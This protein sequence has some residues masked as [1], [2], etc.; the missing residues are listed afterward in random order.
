MLLCVTTLNIYWIALS[1]RPHIPGCFW[2]RRFFLPY[3]RFSTLKL[4]FLAPKNAGFRKVSHV[5]FKKIKQ[6][7]A[8]SLF[9]CGLTKTEVSFNTMMWYVIQRMPC[10]GFYPTIVLAFSCGR[11]RWFV[12]TMSGCE[13]FWKRTQWLRFRYIRTPT[14]WTEP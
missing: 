8:G 13:L 7:N 10:K 4:H 1:S 11:A 3:S 2:K 12:Y 14:W 5:E 6:K 9:S